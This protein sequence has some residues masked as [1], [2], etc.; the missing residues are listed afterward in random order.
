MPEVQDGMTEFDDMFRDIFNDESFNQFIE[1]QRKMQRKFMEQIKKLQETIRS[2]K[3]EGKTE[4]IPLD[5]PGVKG[6]IFRG[7]FGTPG[8]LEEENRKPQ[9]GQKKTERE[10]DL[11]IPEI[12]KEQLREPFVDT[13]TD[14]NEFVALVELPGVEEQDI[15]FETGDDWIQIGAINFQTTRVGV[16]P[17]ADIARLRKTYKNGVLEIRMPFRTDRADNE[18]AKFGMV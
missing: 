5:K 10:E 6:F 12:D 15:K 3:L 16:P 8:L 14:K 18:E 17:N 13:F 2:G 7:I 11:T 4:L 1:E 9:L